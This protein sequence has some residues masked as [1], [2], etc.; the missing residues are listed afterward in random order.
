MKRKVILFILTVGLLITATGCSKQSSSAPASDGNASKKVIT[1]AINNLPNPP[2]SYVDEKNQPIGY[3]IDYLKEL[4]KKLPEYEFKYDAV[5]SNSMLLGVDSGK[6]AFTANYY[7]KNPEREKKYLFASSEYGYSVTALVTKT[8]RNDI[9]T[10][11]DLVGKK[12]VPTTPNS[13]LLY[14]LKDY[15]LKHPDKQINIELIDAITTADGLKYVDSG[16]YDAYYVNAHN[17]DDTNSKLKLD[18]KIAGVISKEPVWILFN[19]NQTELEQKIDKATKE[20]I[21]D[22]TLPK[23]AE[24]WFK[25]DFF[26]SLD[27][28]K[29]G[30]EFRKN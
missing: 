1:I 29:Q 22:G 24:K 4:Q 30:Y 10:L 26:K 13:G 18:L 11:D 21:D 3:T 2:F 25:V 8:A 7:F 19:Q 6:Y 5:D 23:L 15:N 9:K 28:I 16:A 27:Y 12:L 17:F 20:L 14:I